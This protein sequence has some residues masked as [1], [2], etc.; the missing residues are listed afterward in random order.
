M[1][2]K[3]KLGA[4]LGTIGLIA[5]LAYSMKHGKG[6]GGTV[7]FVSLFC[8]SGVLIGNTVTKFYENG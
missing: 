3:S 8:I 6:F 4:T 5:G 2:D 1:M 7:L